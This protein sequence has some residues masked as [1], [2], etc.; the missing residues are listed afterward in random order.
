MG[1]SGW[2][3]D[4][5]TFDQVLISQDVTAVKCRVACTVNASGWDYAF[6]HFHH[7]VYKYLTFTST[8]SASSVKA[9]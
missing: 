7:P 8:V 2:I 5:C 4:N 9:R 1:K 6:N 3:R